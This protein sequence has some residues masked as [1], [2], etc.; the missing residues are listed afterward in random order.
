ME[1]TRKQRI[2]LVN[3]MFH[4]A[5]MQLFVLTLQHIVLI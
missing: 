3:Y 2:V 1:M 4:L 5:N